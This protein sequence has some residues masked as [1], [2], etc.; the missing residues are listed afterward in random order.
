MAASGLLPAQGVLACPAARVHCPEYGVRQVSTPPGISWTARWCAGSGWTRP[1]QPK[2]QD[3]VGIF[4]D[5]DARRVVFTTEGR[6]ADTVARFAVDLTG[7]GGDPEKVTDT[8]SDM[9]RRSSAESECT[10]PTRR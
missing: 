1:P 6:S 2:G 3:Y 7:H 9:R 4:A 10:C 8:S 5:L